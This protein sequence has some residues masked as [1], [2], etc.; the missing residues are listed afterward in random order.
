MSNNKRRL[1]ILVLGTSLLLSGCQSFVIDES[2]ELAPNGLTRT[3]VIPPQS[4]AGASLAKG[5]MDHLRFVYK[6][7]DLKLGPTALY[8]FSVDEVGIRTL[9]TT[10]EDRTP[11]NL[12][13]RA[14]VEAGCRSGQRNLNWF[15]S[16]QI[17]I[18][19]AGKP[20]EGD[21]ITGFTVPQSG[22]DGTTPVCSFFLETDQPLNL[23]KYA[24]DFDL[25]IDAVGDTPP[26]SGV[27]LSGYVKL[28]A[29]PKGVK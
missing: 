5:K 2:T 7:R 18:R 10:E 16:L 1:S 28:R 11:E 22:R 24:P 23:A 9:L 19:E 25:I 12:K 20:G 14:L 29:R 4:I 13:N 15:E 21:L 27:E 3:Q 17:R 26:D 8:N 6:V